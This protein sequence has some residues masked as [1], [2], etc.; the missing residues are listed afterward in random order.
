MSNKKYRFQLIEKLISTEEIASQEELLKKLISQDVQVTQATLS[1][2]LKELKIIKVPTEK[3][4]YR[5][6]LPEEGVT[7]HNT[8]LQSEVSLEFTA[9]LGVLKTKPGYAL[10]LAFE[11][12]NHQLPSL[13]GTIAGNDTI[14]LILRENISRK[15]IIE[16][17]Q[18]ILPNIKNNIS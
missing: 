11:I 2:D 8:I 5:Y 15:K 14:L 17:I 6:Q 13:L 16:E 4:D 10:G 18:T 3:G 12:D 1:R 9:N 7:M